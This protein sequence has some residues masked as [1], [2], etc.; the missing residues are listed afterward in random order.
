MAK[1]SY[2]RGGLVRWF[3]DEGFYHRAD[4]PAW[5]RSDGSQYWYRRGRDHFAYGPSDLYADGRLAWYEDGRH[6]RWRDPYG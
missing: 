3:D 2:L 1:R 5:I 6:L 4:G